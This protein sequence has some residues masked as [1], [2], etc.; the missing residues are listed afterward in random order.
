M[1]SAAGPTEAA[2]EAAAQRAWGQK[3]PQQRCLRKEVRGAAG[4]DAGPHYACAHSTSH[5]RDT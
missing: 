4:V 1:S 2:E 3:S 5:G